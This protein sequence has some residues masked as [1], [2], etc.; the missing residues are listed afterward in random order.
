MRRA[1]VRLVAGSL[2]EWDLALPDGRELATRVRVQRRPPTPQA[3]AGMLADSSSSR[4]LLVGVRRA[5]AHLRA[6]AATGEIDLIAVDENLLVLGGTRYLVAGADATP[7]A[8]VRKVRGRKPW[9]R[10]AVERLLLLSGTAYTQQRLADVL[11][12]SQQA[13]SLA[14]KQIRHVRRIDD[15][16][17]ADPYQGLLEDYLA[18]YPGP[19]G[20]HTYWYGLDPVIE[21]ALTAART[22]L[23]TGTDVLISGDAAADAYAPWRLPARAAIYV[24][25]FVDFTPAGFS[26]STEDEHTLVVRVPADPTIWRTAAVAGHSPLAD[27]LITVHDVLRS[28]GADKDEAAAKLLDVVRAKETV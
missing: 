2:H 5:T 4:R 18:D 7:T 28:T 23:D 16:W 12:V 8:P 3:L 19:G 15:G 13:V 22:C 21:Q 1:D 24:P 6:R 9:V 27:P 11:G 26:P 17:I 14:L 25:E 20:A 10:W